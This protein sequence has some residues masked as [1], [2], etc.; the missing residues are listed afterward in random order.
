MKQN[1]A[2]ESG[3]LNWRILTTLA[4][5]SGSAWLALFSFAATLRTVTYVDGGFTFANPVELTKTPISPIFFQQD[6]EPEIHVDNYGDIYVTAI[7]GVPGGTDLWKSTDKGATFVYLGEPDGAQDKCSTLLQCAGLGGGDDSTDVSP[8][9]YLYVS[10]LWIGNVTVSTSMDGG[11]GGTEPGQAWQVNPAAASVIV[12]DRQWIAAYGPQ[13]LNMTYRQAPGTGALFFNKSTDA[14]KTFGTPVLVRSGNS[15]E[16]NLVVDPYNGNL[17]TTTIPST[18]TN[19]IHLIKSTDGGVTW[20]ESTAYTAPAGANP[21]HKFTVLAIDRGGNLHLV[22]GQSNADGSYHVYLMSS[23]DQGVTWLPAVQVD[24]GTGN[25]AYAVMPWVAA[26]SPGVVDITWLGGPQSPNVFPSSWYVFFAQTTNALSGSP[27]FSQAQVTTKSIHDQ[28]ICFNGSACA[29]NPRQSPGNRDLLEYYTITI[30][31]NGNA[32][33]AYP[34]SLTPDCPSDTCINNSWFTKQTSGNSAYAPP[35]PPSSS[36]FGV[37][38]TLPGSTGK[39]EPNMAVDS[40]NCLYSAAPGGANLWKS[41]DTG[42]TF[43]KLANVPVL[44]TGGGDEDILPLPATTRPATLYYADL[45]LADV[46]IRKSTN[47]GTSW[48]SPGTGGSA[49]EMDASSDRQW[50]AH[51]FVGNV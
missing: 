14:G 38:V 4:L 16:G 43:T 15:T 36:T 20:T 48:F 12:D 47:G 35:P 49:G 1:R 34:D 31:P 45:A 27:T 11:T 19:Q 7:N 13:T 23:T 18:A 46:S 26:G 37:N 40:F 5:C 24:T 30:D 21:A 2:S 25:T 6:G 42:A 10:S 51:D 41:T 9:G 33:I 50:I 22:F 17:Y 8:G 29:A 3:P 39:A 32:N 28:D 44:P